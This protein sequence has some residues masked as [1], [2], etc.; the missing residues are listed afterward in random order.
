MESSPPT[1]PYYPDDPAMAAFAGRAGLFARLH[2][3]LTNPT[4]TEAALFLGRRHFGKTALLTH[5]GAYFDDSFID[6][7]LP[8]KESPLANE[9]EWLLH[10]VRMIGKALAVRDF[11]LTR[12]PE[13]PEDTSQ[14]RQ[15][16]AETYLHELFAVIRYRRLVLLLDDADK[17]IESVQSDRLP[18]D[19]VAYLQ[20]LLE[21]YSQLGI[22]LTLDTEHETSLDMLFPLVNAA[23]TIRL[24]ALPQEASCWLL[25]KPVEGVYTISDES[26]D[27]IHKATGGQPL[28]LQ[29]A[30]YR[31]FE[32]WATQPLPPTS[33][34]T[35]TS[36]GRPYTARES[37]DINLDV[38]AVIGQV[39]KDSEAELRE[40]WQQ[41]TRD[42]RL[43]LTAMVSV[44]YDD[45]LA[46]MDP[47][48]IENWLVETDYPLDLTAIHAALRSLE[49]RGGIR[50]TASGLAITAGFMQ[51]WLLEHARLDE[52]AISARASQPVIAGS[53]WILV[54]A[55][56]V[57]IGLLLVIGLASG[58]QPDASDNAPPTVTLSSGD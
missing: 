49:Y 40:I 15:W 25:Q 42:E 22:T 28:W 39:Y 26:A 37:Q 27:A 3:R 14:L 38:K 54:V 52:T 36:S 57:V 32:R 20:K 33:S 50:N 45:P 19:H 1:N 51:T 48:R 58:G 53:R 44:L 29:R 35:G 46:N 13:P 11:T 24:P 7:Y 34:P 56:L 17:L 55:I 4:H 6:V 47:T 2:Q 8:L 10:V 30:G 5:F 18:V 43:V 41:T 9:E 21:L 23:E 31:L 12:L 16:F